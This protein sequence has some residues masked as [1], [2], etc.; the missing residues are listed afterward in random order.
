MSILSKMTV[1][2]PPAA[3]LI[4]GA[5]VLIGFLLSSL[6]WG[7]LA[8]SAVAMFAPGIFRELGW[9]QDKDEFQLEAARRA[10]FHAY[11]AGGLTAFLLAVRLRVLDGTDPAVQ[12]SSAVEGI[13]VVMWFTW[14]LSSLMS[15]WGPART[16][17]RIL[18]I[19][20][21]VWLV[22]NILAGEGNWKISAMQS[23]LALP[24]FLLAWAGRRWPVAA[25]GVLILVACFFFY[26]FGLQEVFSG[27]SLALNRLPII[28]LFIGPLFASGLALLNSRPLSEG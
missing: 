2:R 10:G 28:V 15:F 21:C 12:A 27:D 5:L 17:V 11:L 9:L 18:L 24:F 1:N 22:F 6:S 26:F 20:G 7:F 4:A 8:I 14:L 16:A 13:L 23:L 25:G 3:T 19:F